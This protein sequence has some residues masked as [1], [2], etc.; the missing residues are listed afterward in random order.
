MEKNKE[1]NNQVIKK[2]ID[3]LGTKNSHLGNLLS[4]QL[5]RLE[6]LYWIENKSGNLQRFKMN[7]AQR[8]L[9][10]QLWYRNDVLKARQL[11]ISTYTALLML[12]MCLFRNNFH[13]GIID[14]TLSD[15]Q[16]K[17]SKMRFA[18]EH[19]D[20]LP[21]GAGEEDTLLAELGIHV[22]QLTGVLKK[23]EWHLK[24]DSKTCIAWSNGSDVR[25]GTNL[26]GGTLQFLHVS[27]LAHVS[28][29]A[30][31]RA[32]EIKTGAINTVG[33]G[34]YIIKES[35]HEG[36]RYG[37]NYELTRE[38]MSNTSKE[39]LSPLDFKFFFFSWFDHAE[40]CLEGR[41]R[42]NRELDKYFNELELKHGIKLSSGRKR[43]YASMYKIMGRSMKQEYPSTPQEALQSAEDGSI[44]GVEIGKIREH[45]RLGVGFDLFPDAPLF[46]SWD[47]GLSDHTSI[48]LVQFVGNKMY[49]VDQ[50][51]NS[52]KGLGHYAL[53]IKAWEEEFSS[54]SMNFLPHDAARRDPHGQSYLEHLAREGIANV[55]VVPRTSDVWLGIN[56]LR[57]LMNDSYF[58]ERTL[59]RSINIKGDSEPSAVEHLELYRCKPACEGT[60]RDLPVHDEHSHTADAARTLAEAWKRG[61]LAPDLPRG[62]RLARMW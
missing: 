5:W 47:L 60:S 23:E 9:H 2:S 51:S 26:R 28:V 6:H 8:K 21:A 3:G 40:Y 35:T 25:I 50:Y 4:S 36:G 24:S 46:T 43:W 1:K 7:P 11:G 61:M 13:C 16:Q 22:K 27:E 39:T 18:W 48:W 44:Y 49:W 38:A 31:W 55:R 14:K 41:E 32:R 20:Y 30:P 17:L 42:W 29:H 58:H 34:G 56:A 33:T 10:D 53:K 54:I 37:I 57:E 15:A 45:G 12:D 19:L 62:K 59:V 52:Q